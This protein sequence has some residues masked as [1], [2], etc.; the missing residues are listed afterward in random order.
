MTSRDDDPV[1][2]GRRRVIAAPEPGLTAA[3][4]IMRAQELRPTLRAAQAEC[5]ALGRVPDASLKALVAAGFFRMIQ[6]HCFGGYEVDVP[7]FYQ[8]VMELARGCVETGWVVSLVGGHTMMVAKFPE[9]AQVDVYGHDGDLR[10]PGALT[11]PGRVIVVDGGYRVTGRW[12]SASGIDGSTH[13]MPLAVGEDQSGPFHLQMLLD[14]DQYD[15][16]DDWHVMGM[17]GTGSKQVV[18]TDVVVPRHRAIRV[19]GMERGAEPFEQTCPVSDNPMY[20]GLIGP[21]L[22]GELA[23]VAVGGARAALDHYEELLRTKTLPYPPHAVRA[24]DPQ[25]RR[26]YGTALRLVATAEAALLNTGAEYMRRVHEWKAQGT[27]LDQEFDVRLKLVE[28]QCVQLAWEAVDLIY[29]TAGTSAS[30][31]QGTYLGR[32][33][34]NLAVLRTHPVLQLETASTVAANIAF[35]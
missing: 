11:P 30:A 9:Q 28:Q 14:R 24:T 13:F 12:V 1:S 23:A 27:P 2:P 33:F 29:R 6:P 5:E 25:Y 10:C 20:S 21:F 26:L 18:A 34:R 22:V 19:A 31:K 35:D 7:S 32:I 8:I 16:V 17:R 3:D 15:I 4:L